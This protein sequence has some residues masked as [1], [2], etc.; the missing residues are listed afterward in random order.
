[1]SEFN[2]NVEGLMARTAHEYREVLRVAVVDGALDQERISG[3][4]ASR[5]VVLKAALKRA[6][7]GE[8]AADVPKAPKQKRKDLRT[9]TPTEIERMKGEFDSMPHGERACVFLMLQ[10]GLRANE[11][12]QLQRRQVEA[13]IDTG[14]LAF[15]RKGGYEAILPS[16]HA[17]RLLEELVAAPAKCEEGRA[18]KRVGEILSCGA[19]GTQ[20]VRL[21]RLTRSLGAR[22]NFC[23]MR[24]HL[25]RH[26]FASQMLR[27]GA[28]LA[29]VQKALGHANQ[30][31]TLRYIHAD[32]SDVEKYMEAW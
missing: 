26:A 14:D 11:I 9:P 16:R 15:T 6:G 12:L 21:Y 19:E 20:Y 1:M 7:L 4:T 18:W 31:T 23:G 2:V 28:S 17:G 25:L 3:W 24:P 13:A 27:R 29:V 10:M 8:L 30:N 5:R 22:I 32:K